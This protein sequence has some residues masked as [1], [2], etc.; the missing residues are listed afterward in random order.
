MQQSKKIPI[1]FIVILVIGIIYIQYRIM[2]IEDNNIK[3]NGRV[4]SAQINFNDIS[5]AELT[6][7][8]INLIPKKNDLF[9]NANIWAKNYILLDATSYYPLAEKNS[10]SKVPI[11]STTKI[12]TATI[13]LEKYNLSDIVTISANAA[14]QI[15]S[16]VMLRSG[17]KLSVESLLYA[18][19]VQSGNDAAMALAENYPDGGLEGFIL[20][21]NTKAKY[22][23][24]KET[25]FKDP[26]GLDDTGH[27]SAFDLAIVTSYIINNPT[28]SKIIK[29]PE[30]TINSI[31]GKLIHKL[32]NSNRLIKGDEPLYYPYALGVKTG[33][34]PEAG[35]CLVSAAEKNGKKIV[36]V[37]LNT[38][39]NTNDASAKESRK[40]L[41]WG[42]SNYIY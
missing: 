40:L 33:F 9:R 20:A 4:K 26:A 38:I 39:E 18:L 36:S 31:D 8:N 28:F 32:E 24:M 41:E 27:S 37:V 5:I 19:L 30:I 35:H 22:L 14:S 6:T 11:A 7:N 23:G 12:M 21:M 1:I 17:E 42:F 29:T 2:R 16:D 13:V 25:Q 3:D 10:H 15:G 34:T